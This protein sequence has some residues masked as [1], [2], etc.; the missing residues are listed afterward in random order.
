V[1]ELRNVLERAAIVQREGAFTP[2][3][4]LGRDF[5]ATEATVAADS[6]R[7]VR[8]LSEVEKDHVRFALEQ[9][10]YNLTHTAEALGVAIS[11]LKRKMKKYGLSRR[12]P[13]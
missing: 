8:P 10:D 4:L 9:L 2:S 1:R 5:T 3:R 12:K 11:T 6:G 7:S 13:G